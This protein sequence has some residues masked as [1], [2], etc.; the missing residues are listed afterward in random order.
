M[1]VD[2]LKEKAIELFENWIKRMYKGYQDDYTTILDLINY[3][4]IIGEIEPNYFLYEYFLD[5]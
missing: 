5:K 4:D 3:I 1:D 2:V